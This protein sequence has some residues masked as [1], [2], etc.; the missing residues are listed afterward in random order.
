MLVKL[1]SAQPRAAGTDKP[2]F[3][4]NVFQVYLIRNA[5]ADFHGIV[6]TVAIKAAVR[7]Y[8]FAMP[9]RF[10]KRKQVFSGKQ[11]TEITPVAYAKTFCVSRAVGK[12]KYYKHC[13]VAVPDGV[14]I[15]AAAA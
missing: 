13:V 11:R 7:D 12:R 1:C 15:Q 3:R 10:A 4:E 9:Q 8:G 6:F 2:E 5:L 14:Y